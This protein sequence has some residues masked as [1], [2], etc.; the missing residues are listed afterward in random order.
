M[1]APRPYVTEPVDP[2]EV[3]PSGA[4]RAYKTA[5]LMLLC[6]AWVL[7]GLVGHGPWKFDDATSFGL[8]QEM[9]QR[10]DFVVPYLAGEPYLLRP[11]L[12]PALSALSIAA[13]SPPLAPYNAAR[14]V[15]GLVLA[16][17][18]LF[19]AL[20]SREFSGRAY[21]WLPVLILV[22]SLG[23]WDRSHAMSG[24]LGLTLGIAMALYGLALALR[25]PFAGGAWLGLGIAVAFGSRGLQG[26]AWL[27]LTMALLPFAGDTWR[28]R[29]YV[30]T[31]GV[32]VAVAVALSLP[33]AF[34]LE[35]RDPALFALWWSGE[36]LNSYIGFLPGAD[37]VSPL[38]Q[39]R[40]LPWFAWPALPLVIW[41][42]WTRG[43]G[44]NGGLAQPGIQ[45]PGILALVML[46]NL[47]VMPGPRVIFAAPLLVPLALV[48][49]LEVDSLKRGFSAFLDWFGILTFGLLAIVVWLLWIDARVNGMSSRIA[50]LFQDTEIGFQPTFHLG[51]ILLAIFLTALWVVLV[52]PA[53]RSNRRAV[54]NWAAGVTLLW[55]LYSTIWLPYLDS[56]RSYKTMMEGV[57]MHLLA[58]GCVASRNLGEPQRALFQYYAGLVTTREEV[59]PDQRCPLL[60]VQYGRQPGSAP[61]LDGFDIV[62]DGRRRGDETERFVLYQRVPS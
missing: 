26:P 2:T 14:V 3:S 31:V 25:R 7:L 17:M 46:V 47:V 40:N 24:E 51:T 9:V 20:A 52:R 30:A 29:A 41:T 60:L 10:G 16:L 4:Y 58:P 15:V 34:A 13:L 61:A 19:A 45:V 33:W 38:Y 22:G 11:P 21:R 1:R 8:A 62:W 6:G 54:L 36:A 53:R 42:L 57:A 44:F 55:G 35:A 50:V 27:A 39:L 18:L 5:G 56:R 23:F 48:G 12:L 43:R 37:T 59:H 32:A 28:S 49:T